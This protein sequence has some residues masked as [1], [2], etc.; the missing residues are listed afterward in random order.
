MTL[1]VEQRDKIYDG[2][3]YRLGNITLQKQKSG[4]FVNPPVFPLVIITFQTEG[5]EVSSRRKI[6][7]RFDPEHGLRLETYGKQCKA[8]I[9]TVIEALDKR[10][11]ELLADL[12]S[13]TLWQSEVG[14]NP[15][16]DRMQFRGA[17]P[18]IF[19]DPYEIELPEGRRKIY[20]CVVDFFVE[21]EFS[22]TYERPIITEIDYNIGRIHIF[23]QKHLQT[24]SL[25]MIL[26]YDF[27]RLG[28]QT[29]SVDMILE[30]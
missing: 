14:I 17:D 13:H 18:P 6:R 27:E 12:Y 10:Q 25:D 16:D 15:I 21:Y 28:S 19:I 8:T 29:F 3:P 4:Q 26:I 22:W 23:K 2:I 30:R 24:Y 5:V 9:S 11:M 1:T 20:R 7:E